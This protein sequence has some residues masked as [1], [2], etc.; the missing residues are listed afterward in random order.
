VDFHKNMAFTDWLEI[1]D[2]STEIFITSLQEILKSPNM[3]NNKRLFTIITSFI[4]K[5]YE[6][7]KVNELDL[8]F[9]YFFIIWA[10]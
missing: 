1:N 10:I 2:F 7:K 6:Y 8:N 9:D 3:D 4:F 5:M